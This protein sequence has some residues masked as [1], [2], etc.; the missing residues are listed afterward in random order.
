MVRMETPTLAMADASILLLERWASGELP[1][2]DDGDVCTW[3]EAQAEL[4]PQALA[5][6]EGDCRITY[7]ELDARANRL[8]RRLCDAGV[9][10]GVVVAIAME[11][12]IETAI[13]MLGIMKAGAAF[14]PLDIG[15]PT[16]RLTYI[17]EDSGTALILFRDQDRL[18]DFGDHPSLEVGAASLSGCDT[19]DRPRVVVIDA[20]AYVIYT[21]GSTGRPKGV[22]VEHRSLVNMVA[23]H[24]RNLGM[25]PSDITLQLA[26]AA[27]DATQLEWWS[28]L[29]TGASVH[30]V[31]DD[32]RLSPA[33]LAEW[34]AQE[35]VTVAFMPTPLGEAFMA[36]PCAR[37]GALR[38]LY[39]GGD[40]L[41]NVPA[42]LPY[43]VHNY[44]GPTES[45]VVCTSGRVEATGTG[46]PAPG[47]GYPIAGTRIYLLNAAGQRVPVGEVG[48]LYVGGNGLAR[49]YRN[50][51]ELTAQRFVSDPFS[52]EPR[53]RMY[54]TG[55]RAR[56]RVDGCLEFIGR[57]D[58]QVKIRG[59]RIEL[60]EVQG[61]LAA[62][63][64]VRA[65]AVQLSSDGE[66][67]LLGYVELEPGS[68]AR[69]E[70]LLADLSRWLPHYMLPAG[71][72]IL[73]RMPIDRN[74]KVDGPGLR[75]LE[76]RSVEEAYVE[77]ATPTEKML[78]AIWADLFAID[79][80]TIS[81]DANLFLLGG[82]SL[83]LVR[84]ISALR[85]SLGV[86]LS[87]TVL[88]E[89]PVLRDMAATV[90]ATCAA[91]RKDGGDTASPE[92]EEQEW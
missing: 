60:G 85:F 70:D 12:S 55:D 54:A 11:R 35:G 39:V 24:R 25:R 14:L 32:T 56:Y 22:E 86:T 51:P 28:A 40:A 33:A 34:M 77:P 68:A 30:V 75:A 92:I 27:F 67:R 49:G 2:V 58:D 50:R 59:Y 66:P 91:A 43:V 80:S 15:H 1:A 89:T 78:A 53:A 18:P 42:D 38:L 64:A 52:A 16:E 48:E 84:L 19:P 5:V 20:L 8:A 71:L 29:T 83:L 79:A 4:T 45:T 31:D 72:R 47:I 9:G 88:F 73:D 13:S 7:A 17:L 21:S 10:I 61:A 46:A 65:A 62:L 76:R 26:G 37:Q 69:A 41:R 63:P 82:H 81:A 6:R 87:L 57:T 90:D 36:E 44:Y 23:W 3:F 74:G